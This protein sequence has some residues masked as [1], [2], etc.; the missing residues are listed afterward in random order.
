[1][2]VHRI[3]SLD[4]PRVH[5]YANLKDRELARE[6]GLFIAEGEHLVRR[7]IASD[8]PVES[9]LLAEQ[10]LTRLQPVLPP[11]ATILLAP[12]AV[13]DGILGYK[14]HS[15]IMA[16][17]C[18]KPSPPLDHLVAGHAPGQ[19]ATLLICPEVINHD[20]LGTLIRIAAAFGASGVLV[21]ELSCDPYWRR[22]VRVSMGTI[23]HLPIVR[24]TDIARDMQHLRTVLGFELV[25][26]VLDEQASA[27]HGQTRPAGNRLGLVLGSESQGL[28]ER[29]IGLCD[30][31]VTIPMS[32]GTDSLNIAIAA[33][34]FM[35]HYTRTVGPG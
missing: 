2:T 25:A 21:G 32:L 34:V 10:H 13:V 5:P 26:T 31:R 3:Q 14:F 6:G 17:G 28:P 12:Q 33:A 22:S 30:R 19:P 18:R 4:D 7:L 23:F 15:G 11:D 9:I 16:V 24:S 20:N 29:L 27:L 35:H 1:M 8:Y